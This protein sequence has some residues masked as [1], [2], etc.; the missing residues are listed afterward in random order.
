MVAAAEVGSLVWHFGGN[1]TEFQAVAKRVADTAVRMQQQVATASSR[2]FSEEK[3][4]EDKRR[5]LS[6]V[7][8]IEARRAALGGLSG[9]QPDTSVEIQGRRVLD[10]LAKEKAAREGILTTQKASTAEAGKLGS[11]TDRIT[12]G[13]IKL[14]AAIAIAKATLSALDAVATIANARS[15]E[16]AGKIE[17]SLKANESAIAKVRSVPIVGDAVYTAV[18]LFGTWEQDIDAAKSA[19]E[20]MSRELDNVAQRSKATRD[21][22]TAGD[23]AII[24]FSRQADLITENPNAG[25]G[26]QRAEIELTAQED[27][28]AAAA[29]RDAA[30]T[31]ALGDDQRK[32]IEDN[33]KHEQRQAQ[34]LRDARL[35]ENKRQEQEEYD[36]T[37][38]K[39]QFSRTQMD[40]LSAARGKDALTRFNADREAQRREISQRAEEDIKALRKFSGGKETEATRQRQG[41]KDQ[42]LAGFDADTEEQRKQLIA[43]REQTITD[44]IGNARQRRMR[45]NGQNDAADLDAIRSNYAKQI[46]EAELAGEKEL[47]AKLKMDQADAELDLKA[48]QRRDEQ[49]SVRSLQTDTEAKRLEM[50]G[51]KLNADLL[52]LNSDFE[53]KKRIARENGNTDELAALEANQKAAEQ[54]LRRNGSRASF[55]GIRESFNNIQSQVYNQTSSNVDPAALAAKETTAAVKDGLK[56]D[57]PVNK[58]LKELGALL[59]TLKPGAL[60]P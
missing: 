17:D 39:I 58:N 30:L 37:V 38:R 19:L 18:G 40:I 15:L 21:A 7:S 29:R 35:A 33:F 49:I 57:S 12:S 55:S 54:V 6:N 28:G 51:Q 5:T 60:G 53:E 2:R 41:Q 24:G 43:R 46:R 50:R 31:T 48:K 23:R 56:E 45:V 4:I 16:Q 25:F 42:E 10:A 52:R 59:K 34:R 14:G 44:I 22:I 8:P 36:G 32:A 47:A 9:P 13:A 11:A 1:D 27:F 20:R 26:R 3:A